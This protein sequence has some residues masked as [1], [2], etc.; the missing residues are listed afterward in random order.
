MDRLAELRK[1]FDDLE[2]P[3]RSVVMPL[4]EELVYLEGR[5]VEL[6]KMP[7]IKVHPSDPTLQR[8]TQAARQYREVV[9]QYNGCVKTLLTC[10]RKG[11]SGQTSPLREGLQKLLTLS[12]SNL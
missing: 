4:L 6:K 11:D 1:L 7:M 3:A 2:E 5:L 8:Q 10:C 12:A 9:Q